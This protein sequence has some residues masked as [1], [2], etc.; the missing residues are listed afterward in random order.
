MKKLLFLPLLA[1]VTLFSCNQVDNKEA[2]NMELK[3]ELDSVSYALGMDIATNLKQ[4]KLDVISVDIMAEAMSAV[5][6][7][8]ETKLKVEEAGATIQAYMQ[9]EQK[10]QYAGV[11]A[12]GEKFMLENSTKEGVIT[13]ASGLQYKVIEEGKGEMPTAASKV[14]VF[15]KGSFLNGDVFDSNMGKDAI[16]FGVG[17]VIPG[18]T[19]GLQL[20]KAGAK[21]EF[22]IPY[23]IAYGERGMGQS[24][25]P[26][27]SLIFEVELI[28]FE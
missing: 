21:F 10:Q 22:Y 2:K 28:S 8:T 11:I 5:F 18:W 1:L 7:G 14:K 15:Y 17:Q 13:T 3:S 6:T 27:S 4:A 19:E 9:K 25:P 26:Y 12:E 16:E 23:H 20:M 24:I